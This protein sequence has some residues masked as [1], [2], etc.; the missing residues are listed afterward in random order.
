MA[1]GIFALIIVPNKQAAVAAAYS[2]RVQAHP[3]TT[4][5]ILSDVNE[6]RMAHGIRPLSINGDIVKSSEAKCADMVAKNYYEHTG[7]DGKTVGGWV[8]ETTKN[9]KSANENLNKGNFVASFEV[10]D[11]WMNSPDHKNTMLDAKFTDTGIAICDYPDGQKVIVQ[12][13]VLYYTAEEIQAA[14]PKYSN[15]SN[16]TTICSTIGGSYGI[17]ITTYC[18]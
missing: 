8:G 14:Q 12:Q 2:A 18:H 13:F 1:I 10:V 17:P 4:A 3:L 6:Q 15:V 5:S 7:P 16:R 9:W 11:S